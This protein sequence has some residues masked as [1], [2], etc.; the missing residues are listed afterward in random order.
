MNA[1]LPFAA[2]SHGRAFSPV[3][4]SPRNRRTEP[5]PAESQDAMD[6]ALIERFRRGDLS[7]YD[8]IVLRHRPRVQALVYCYMNNAEDAEEVTQDALLHVY[9]G[10]DEFR[11]TTSFT[12][13]LCTIA[14]HLGHS[15]RWSWCRYKRRLSV[16]IETPGVEDGASTLSELLLASSLS[17]ADHL[18]REDYLG[19]ISRC[20]VRLEK[21]HRDPLT[22]RTRWNAR[23][24]DIAAF[25]KISV[26]A[27]KSR[28]LRGRK[29]LQLLMEADGE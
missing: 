16:S 11:G 6:L 22:Y 25:L 28:L 12:S 26:S 17:P 14:V 1:P 19:Q 7:A 27:L 9:G 21:I 10:L 3:N 5:P 15:R 13:W 20:M 23:Y 4:I 18:A 24:I 8:E 29:E 2:R